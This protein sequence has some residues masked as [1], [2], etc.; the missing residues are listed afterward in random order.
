MWKKSL[1]PRSKRKRKTTSRDWDRIFAVLRGEYETQPSPSLNQLTDG[2]SSPWQILVATILSLRTKDAVTVA[3]SRKL[4]AVAPDP[5]STRHL[6][7]PELEQLIYPAGFYRTK[8]RQIVAIAELLEPRDEVPATRERLLELPGVGRK[9]AN[10]VLNLAFGVDAICVDTHVHRIP[11]RLGWISTATPE[12][13]EK[14]LEAVWPQSHWIE[15]NA[16]LVSFGQQTC[17]PVLPRCSVC[18]FEQECERKGV[19]KSR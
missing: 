15:A 4:F 16:L 3:A 18:P 2:G 8:A 17:T 19:G 9:T 13:S 12:E 10:L 14:A 5:R 1:S 6:T 11:N 7:A